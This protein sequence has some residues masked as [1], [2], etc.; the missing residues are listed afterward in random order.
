MFTFR[1][2]LQEQQ[3]QQQQQNKFYQMRHTYIYL[4]QCLQNIPNGTG[5]QIP[6]P[7]SLR[8]LNKNNNSSS[9][10][11]TYEITIGNDQFIASRKQ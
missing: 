9:N 3:Q 8:F 10:S 11:D 6:S 7:P 1:H 4:L 2:M 5:K